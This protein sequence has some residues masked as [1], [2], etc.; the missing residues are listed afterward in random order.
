MYKSQLLP[1]L[2]EA[3]KYAPKKNKDGET[4]IPVLAYAKVTS[5]N[6]IL[7]IETTDLEKH[8]IGTI[9]S[10]LSDMQ[11]LI[12]IRWFRDMINVLDKSEIEFELSNCCSF[13]TWHEH[14]GF[15]TIEQSALIIKQNRTKL[16]LKINMNDTIDLTEFPLNP[17]NNGLNYIEE[18]IDGKNFDAIVYTYVRE[19]DYVNYDAISRKEK[20]EANK[21]FPKYLIIDGLVAKKGKIQTEYMF[22][23][24]NHANKYYCDYQISHDGENVEQRVFVDE[25]ENYKVVGKKVK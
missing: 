7:T 6:N 3:S 10:D 23:N 2:K 17:T 22:D 11:F 24:G 8:F 5:L 18:K 12:D 20:S 25:I 21:L 4:Y 19:D 16:K 1:L 14:E 15:I 9:K 13:S